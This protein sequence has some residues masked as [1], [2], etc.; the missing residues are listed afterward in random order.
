MS[1]FFLSD[2]VI[3]LQV[4]S[5]VGK[6]GVTGAFGFICLIVTEL[7]PTVVRNM[8]VGVGATSGLLSSIIAPYILYTGKSFHNFISCKRMYHVPLLGPYF[9]KCIYF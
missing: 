4:L 1:R 8:G 9:L 6:T 5:L 7:M 2:N 3:V